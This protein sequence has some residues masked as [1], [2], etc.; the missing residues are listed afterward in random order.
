MDMPKTKNPTV[1]KVVLKPS[2]EPSEDEVTRRAF[3]L[4]KVLVG[5]FG[6]DGFILMHGNRWFEYNDKAA[7]MCS[8]H[9]DE[10][11]LPTLDSAQMNGHA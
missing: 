9:R 10:F 1:F 3:F 2:A 7:A 4:A 5:V 8:W 11:P 6:E